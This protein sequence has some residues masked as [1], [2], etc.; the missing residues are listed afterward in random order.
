[1]L[2]VISDGEDNQSQYKLKQVLNTLRESNVILYAVGLLKPFSPPSIYGVSGKDALKK[3]AEATEALRSFR[4]TSVKSR[5]FAGEL[6]VIC[7]T[8]TR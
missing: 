8:S 5:R 2:I 7:G 4:R 1:V 3:L 6:P